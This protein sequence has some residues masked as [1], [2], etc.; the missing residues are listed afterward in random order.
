MDEVIEELQEQIDAEA[1]N[2]AKWSQE[3][4]ADIYDALAA[5]CRDWA[6]QI[7]SEIE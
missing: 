5:H 3:E 1:G 6:Q 4:S 2:S 7:R